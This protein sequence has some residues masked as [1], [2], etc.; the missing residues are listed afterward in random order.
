MV[1]TRD[2][3]VEMNHAAKYYA[4]WLFFS[5][6]PEDKP[7]IACIKNNFVEMFKYLIDNDDIETVQKVLDYGKFLGKHNID[8]LILYAIDNKH[9]EIQVMLTN[10]KRE[11][12]GYSDP[13][14]KLKL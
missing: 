12:I 7:T 2:F 8:E 5:H 13:T 9:I 11:K 4:I 3:S 10:Y 14:K 6:Y 1:V